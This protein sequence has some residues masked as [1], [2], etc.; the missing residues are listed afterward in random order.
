MNFTAHIGLDNFLLIYCVAG[1]ISL[2][3]PRRG[4]GA[5]FVLKGCLSWRPV[6]SPTVNK[7]P[8]VVRPPQLAASFIFIPQPR[9]SL[10]ES[11]PSRESL[12]RPIRRLSSVHAKRPR[13][14]KHCRS[15]AGIVSGASVHSIR[16]Q[17]FQQRTFRV[18]VPHGCP[19]L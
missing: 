9:N 3:P 2:S 4:T 19:K 11:G 12:L 18:I 5:G 6:V 16:V 8:G 17:T 10:D 13:A 1:V 15:F 7:V 14:G